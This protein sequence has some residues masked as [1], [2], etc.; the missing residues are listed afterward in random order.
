MPDLGNAYVNIVPKAE[1][2]STNIEKVLAGGNPGAEKAGTGIGKKLLGAVAKLGIGAAVGSMLKQS[3]EAGGKLQ[4]SFGGLETIYGDAAEAAKDYARE[5]SAAG[6][7][8]NTYAEQAVSMGAALK[9]AFGGDTAAAA[10]AA[11]TA[12]MDMADNA[13][14]M[15]TPIESLQSAYQGFAKQNYTMLDNLKLGYGGTKQEMERLLADAEKITGVK[16]DINNLG[17]VYSAIH[18]IQGELGLTGVAAEKASWENLMGAM[19][20]GEGFEQAMEGLTE[21]VGNF[22]SN[23][24]SM[25]GNLAPKLPDLILGLADVVIANAPAFIAA[26]AELIVKLA[27]GLVERIPDI[28][29]KVPEIWQSFKSAFSAIDWKSLGNDLI[30]KIG[31]GINAMKAALK[32]KFKTALTNAKGALSEIDWKSLGSDIIN[33]IINGLTGGAGSLYRKVRDIIKKALTSGQDEAETGSPSRLFARELGRWIPAGVAMGAEEN[34]APLDKVMRGMID[35]SVTTAGRY[36]SVAP[37]PER[38][39]DADR[40]IDALQRLRL[41]VVVELKGDAGAFLRVVNTENF[42]RTTATG[43]N[44]LAAAPAR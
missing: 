7:S 21:S 33:G 16:Y 26:G 5:A 31:D 24:L 14:K 43:Y 13:A 40:I 23:V 35:G 34:M 2:I 4:Q 15:G 32:T 36:A 38:E 41:G 10:D 22:A 25:L 19:T 18:V 29:A 1:N 37:A 30:N 6:I 44:R 20:T 8:A 3:F 9:A 12:I 27:A 11:N 17:D 42:T 28:A 39:D